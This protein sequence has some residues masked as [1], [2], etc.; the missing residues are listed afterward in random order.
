MTSVTSHSASFQ[1]SQLPDIPAYLKP[2]YGYILRVKD[3]QTQAEI[4]NVSIRADITQA[5][6]NLQP[7]GIYSFL[8]E[9]YRAHGDVIET[10]QVSRLVNAALRLSDRDQGEGLANV[11]APS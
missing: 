10:I 2:H 1:W 3:S 9:A 4:R 8:L 5:T 6:V 7:G 11:K